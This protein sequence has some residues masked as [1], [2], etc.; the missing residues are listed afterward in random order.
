MA[1]LARLSLTL[2]RVIGLFRSWVMPASIALKR[3]AS[4][5]TSLEPLSG[6][7]ASP[8]QVPTRAMAALRCLSGRCTS[9]N[10]NSPPASTL[11]PSIDRVMTKGS[12]LNRPWAGSGE[13]SQTGSREERI[14][15]QTPRT[16]P[17]CGTRVGQWPRRSQR[18]WE[19]RSS[20][21]PRRRSSLPL[22]LGRLVTSSW[23]PFSCDTA[24]GG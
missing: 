9:S 24:G 4:W 18:S 13:N 2:R 23:K 22:R 10:R 20:W 5:R 19:R 6:T 3:V 7:I 1:S 21:A 15:I 14:R 11:P 17:G 8:S 16:F 12:G